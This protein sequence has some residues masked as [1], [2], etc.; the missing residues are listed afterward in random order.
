MKSMLIISILTCS[1]VAFAEPENTRLACTD[2]LDND[3]DG[4]VDCADQDCWDLTM[5]ANMV[6]G[7]PLPGA[8]T[9]RKAATTRLVLGAI[10]LPLGFLVGAGSA[11]PFVAANG[12]GSRD[13]RYALYGVGGAMDVLAVAGIAAGIALLATGAGD[14][15]ALRD[16]RVQLGATSLRVTF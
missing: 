12:E 1:A 8:P 7:T 3:G 4:R 16:R 13:A 10:L 11:G 15:A 9:P 6:P 14:L 2:H 5:C